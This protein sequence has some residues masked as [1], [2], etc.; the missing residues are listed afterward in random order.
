MLHK[1]QHYFVQ[2]RSASGQCYQS[3]VLI[4]ANCTQNLISTAL[5][6]HKCIKC[7]PLG[8]TFA[9]GTLRDYKSCFAAKESVNGSGTEKHFLPPYGRTSVST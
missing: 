4:A 9:H 6:T 1:Q 3:D 5:R 2:V 8:H 7:C